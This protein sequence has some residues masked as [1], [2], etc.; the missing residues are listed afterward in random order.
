MP[1]SDIEQDA[2]AALDEQLLIDALR[3]LLRI[4]GVTGQEAD[5]QRWLGQHMQQLGL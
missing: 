2:L 3:D 5:A 1:L 4:P